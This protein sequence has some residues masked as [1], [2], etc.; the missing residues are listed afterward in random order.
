M[1]VKSE[2][3]LCWEIITAIAEERNI[4]REAIQER[5]GDVIDVAAL[6]RLAE[7]STE[8]DTV[9]LSVS[10]RVADCFVTVTDGGRVRAS[11]PAKAETGRIGKA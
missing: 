7:Q 10:F 11:C 3:N 8:S 6:E 1:T 4:E 5:L 9:E 2:N